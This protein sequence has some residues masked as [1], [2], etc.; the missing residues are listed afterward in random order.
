MLTSRSCS[1]CGHMVPST[2]RSCSVCGHDSGPRMLC[3]CPRCNRTRRLVASDTGTDTPVPLADLIARAIA[4]LR[5]QPPTTDHLA[6]LSPHLERRI[7]MTANNDNPNAPDTA[8]VTR[9]VARTPVSAKL[10]EIIRAL[11][12]SLMAEFGPFA[13][14]YAILAGD[15]LAAASNARD[16]FVPPIVVPAPPESGN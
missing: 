8:P 13:F 3:R 1:W 7:A 5:S 10:A 12:E 4:A 6:D 11:D 15:G 16:G 9:E 2:A 14:A